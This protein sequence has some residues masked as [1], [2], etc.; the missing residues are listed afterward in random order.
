MTPALLLRACIPV[1]TAL[2]ITLSP[3]SARSA[4]WDEAA[5]VSDSELADQ[6]GG[7]LQA[8]GVSFDFGAVMQTTVNG[9]VI[10]QT[11]LNWTSAGAT[12]S[13]QIVAKAATTLTQA[14]APAGTGLSPQASVADGI[15]VSAQQTALLQQISSNGLQN[16]IA[17]AANNQAINQSLTVTLTL[18]HGAQLQSLAALQNLARSLNQSGSTGA[19]S[20]L[21]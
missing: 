2:A 10:A 21:H 14:G 5:K 17:N 4:G 15:S 19:I 20:S 16:V 3:F 9:Q 11:V 18:L 6:R 1:A 7:Y 12:V 13:Q 8:D